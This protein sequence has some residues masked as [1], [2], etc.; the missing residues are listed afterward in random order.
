MKNMHALTTGVIVLTIF[1]QVH[2]IMSIW[3]IHLRMYL[4][5]YFQKEWWHMYMYVHICVHKLCHNYVTV[6]VRNDI[7]IYSWPYIIIFCF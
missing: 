6:P 5:L 4:F 2:A 7:I 1:E 3:Y